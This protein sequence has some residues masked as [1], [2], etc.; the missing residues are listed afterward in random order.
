MNLDKVMRVTE[1]RIKTSQT[2]QSFN[3]QARRTKTQDPH[4][5]IEYLCLTVHHN[6][7]LNGNVS[8][9]SARVQI[10]PYRSTAPLYMSMRTRVWWSLG[11]HV[12]PYI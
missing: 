7:P 11:P 8:N 1:N 2:K 10:F 5:K 12:L 4:A 3:K 6:C 9:S